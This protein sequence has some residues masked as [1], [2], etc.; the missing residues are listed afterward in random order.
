MEERPVKDRLV[1]CLKGV[2]DEVTAL[3]N[4]IGR[5]E[6][7][8]AP[9]PDM[10]SFRELLR[11]MA[12]MER[13]CIAWVSTGQELVWESAVAWSGE[14]LESTLRDLE[15]VRKQTTTYLA[16]C[17]EEQ[18]EQPMPALWGSFL[19]REMLEP[20]EM[21]RWVAMHEYYHLGQMVSYRW[22][23]GHNPY[24]SA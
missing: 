3:S 1:K 13:I 2:R 10:K 19:G 21:V 6:F 16:S 4:K 18:L 23:L 11:E 5:D 22:I 15:R 20:E 14:D 7:N 8:W 24:R 17:T 12:T 9:R